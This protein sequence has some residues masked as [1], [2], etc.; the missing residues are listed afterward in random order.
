MDDT[1]ATNTS[2][3][4]Y[5]YLQPTT[6]KRL[7]FPLE[8]VEE[9]LIV[10]ANAL[11]SIERKLAHCKEYN[12]LNGDLPR[13]KHITRMIYKISTIMKLMKSLAIDMDEMYL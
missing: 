5:G 8:N 12:A 1:L 10:A 7:P 3:P 4:D 2:T 6:T 11:D 9:T 13:K